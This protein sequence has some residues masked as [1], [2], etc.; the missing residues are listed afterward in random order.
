MPK[1]SQK[2]KRSENCDFDR[3]DWCH[4]LCISCDVKF[5]HFESTAVLQI[6]YVK[7][8]IEKLTDN[9]TSATLSYT[10]FN[11]F[12]WTPGLLINAIKIKT[13]TVATCHRTGAEAHYNI[14]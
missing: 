4:V 12:L 14:V 11:D 13:T 5:P 6:K 9:N 2:Q 1:F 10:S 3:Y 8:T 7:S